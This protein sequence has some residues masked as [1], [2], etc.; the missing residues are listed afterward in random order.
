MGGK[1]VGGK[2]P[3]KDPEPDDDEAPT[4]KGS[5]GPLASRLLQM[6]RR[7]AP[8]HADDE[9]E[10]EQ[11]SSALA[12]D[13]DDDEEEDEEDEG[14]SS[15][16]DSDQEEQANREAMAAF[17]EY[18][19]PLQEPQSLKQNTD[20]PADRIMAAARTLLFKKAQ[21][22][23]VPTDANLHLS[24]IQEKAYRNRIMLG[25]GVQFMEQALTFDTESLAPSSI[26]SSMASLSQS[27][28]A[29]PIRRLVGDRPPVQENKKKKMRE[30]PLKADLIQETL[31][32][33]L[34]DICLN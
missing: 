3:L 13:E 5:K 11:G 20:L 8:E 9:Q 21:Q 17:S 22:P 33:C 16:E 12:Q 23:F 7:L 2:R 18:Q 4:E 19:Q 26:G 32:V 34:W 30:D 6:K 25:Y 27:S 28:M 24:K 31:T 29:G 10:L 15:V 1:G 14:Q